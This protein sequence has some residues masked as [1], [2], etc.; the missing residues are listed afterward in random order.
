ME[1]KR[2]TS[3]DASLV[4][5]SLVQSSLV[6]TLWASEPEW[7]VLCSLCRPVRSS[8]AA[9]ILR[10]FPSE[11]QQSTEVLTSGNLSVQEHVRS[12]FPS[13]LQAHVALSLTSPAN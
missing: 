8:M 11:E 2:A 12:C 9:L 4:Q 7:I 13:S 1:P 6:P 3:C 10:H 5:S